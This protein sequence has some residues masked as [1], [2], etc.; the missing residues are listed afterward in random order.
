MNLRQND[1]FA[2][3][4]G[5]LLFL[6]YSFFQSASV[7][8]AVDHQNSRGRI[9]IITKVALA[10]DG[11]LVNAI[12]GD[13]AFFLICG[14][15]TLRR[16][17]DFVVGDSVIRF[18]I[19]SPDCDTVQIVRW[20]DYDMVGRR[21]ALHEF[22]SSSGG[23]VPELA[24]P[25][26]TASAKLPTTS[27]NIKVSGTKSFSADVS[28]NGRTNLSQ[29]LALTLSGDIG[30]G[31][32]VKGSFSDRG[33]RDSR[34]VTK[35][36]SELDNVY[37]EVE[38]RRLSGVFGSYQF[39]EDRFHYLNMS[40]NVQGLGVKY[41]TGR[42]T[43]ESS[44][45]V[46]PGNFSEYTF[47]TTD[48]FYGP[49]RAQGKNGESGIAVIENSETVWLNGA[50]L[51]R[52]RDRDYY[53]DYPRGEL[54]FTGRAAIDNQDRVRVDFEYQRLEY[55]KT[56]VTGAIIDTLPGD[57]V[58]L[59]IGYAG[60]LSSK[61]DPLDFALSDSDI[62]VLQAAGDD[63]SKAVVPGARYV[64]S[65]LGDYDAQVDSLQDTV[66]VYVGDRNGSFSVTFSQVEDGDYVYLGGGRYQFVGKGQGNYQPVRMLP[67]PE[68]AQVA[69][70]RSEIAASRSLRLSSEVGLSVYD[71][72]RSSSIGDGENAKAAGFLGLAYGSN[73]QRV[74]GN[75]SAE[76]LPAGF[77]RMG[78]LDNV[79]ESYLW[80]R[81]S[82][83]LG[84]RR[85]YLGD[86]TVSLGGHDR[87]RVE[88][89][90]TSEKDGFE[91]KRVGLS[92]QLAKVGHSTIGIDFNLSSASDQTGAN[93]LVELKPSYRFALNPMALTLKGDY[94][95][96]K[97]ELYRSTTTY[98]SKR[99]GEIG[100]EYAG[101][102]VTARQR[103]NWQKE[104]LWN[105]IDS[106][107]SLTFAADRTMGGRS[108]LNIN[109][110][111]NRFTNSEHRKTTYQ[112][113]ML[114][115]DLPQLTKVLDISANMRLN[116]RGTS[117]TSKTYLKVDP[118]QGDYV[119]IDSVYVAQTHGD[120]I[121]VT[122]QVGTLTPSV[123]AEKRVQI[124]V[125]LEKFA[126]SVVTRGTTVRYETSLHE[127]GNDEDRFAA[128]W[129][130]PPLTYL[131]DSARFRE[132]HDEY[133][134]RRYDRKIGL[135]S[136]LSFV[137]R[138]ENTLL[139]VS[140]P[141]KRNSEQLRLLLNQRVGDRDFVELTGTREIAFDEQLGLYVLTI[142]THS[143]KLSGTHVR[144]HWEVGATV[145][146][147]KE[148]A[149]SLTLRVTT[150]RATPK[151]N[152]NL[153]SKGRVET[154][155]FVLHVTEADRRTILLQMADGFPVGTH[156]G[157]TILADF[158]FADNFSFRL[159]G[160]G[161]VREGEKDRYF[162]R[163]ELLSRFQ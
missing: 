2:I 111:L 142:Q 156:L 41:R 146:L 110:T 14:A 92:T 35:R 32:V 151:V 93:R 26:Q 37:L 86:L 75:A 94:D 83:Q 8:T 150:L 76:Y 25:S 154:S 113:G 45:S 53:F 137:N 64:G 141:Q 42:G 28:E 91:S 161:E 66:F 71:R 130:V 123:E 124:D 114:N 21:Y 148:K 79:D 9:F 40:R 72:N 23:E 56:L 68:A 73:S 129:L 89:G 97:I 51:T 18:C 7:A 17:R 30:N 147:G 122:E 121:V 61:N 104:L 152:Y 20:R 112:T 60:L 134:L 133:R 127:I 27:S 140:R 78:R 67:L 12:G 144:G 139:D 69:V 81:T 120:Y 155:V 163:T 117:Q 162:L 58:R 126:K 128:R 38:S 98:N 34:M 29:G 63:A 145:E 95:N 88:A 3:I 115:L 31:V 100:L 143:L 136:E 4:P 108:K 22:E 87:S 107:Q 11:S 116:R 70:V 138:R 33:L 84:D 103:E 118:G 48:G 54:Y 159:T 46:P 55:R 153:S 13:T 43:V 15:D 47:T 49:Y 62:A 101:V 109:A 80:Q 24:V 39:K 96:R 131:A 85:R 19:A 1:A 44:V 119:L 125:D 65:G 105:R 10:S 59:S 160:Q 82:Q 99:E 132:R 158:R 57:K 6:W 16:G 102:S 135:R 106:K 50:K 5:I 157:G 90:Y 52:G 77:A 36:F 74:K 149:D